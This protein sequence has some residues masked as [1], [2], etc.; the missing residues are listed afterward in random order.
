[1]PPWFLRQLDRFVP[2]ARRADPIELR[3]ARLLVAMLLLIAATVPWNSAVQAS[4]GH[5]GLFSISTSTTAAFVVMLLAY[6]RYN[7]HTLTTHLL[8]GVGYLGILAAAVPSGLLY[9]PV[10]PI[11]S[12][13]P[14]IA[15]ALLDNRRAVIWAGLALLAIVGLGVGELAGLLDREGLLIYFQ[16][17]PV[18]LN[19]VLL[20]GYISG[21]G[22]FLNSLN[23]EQRRATDAAR[24]AA[25]AANA[26]KSTFL[27][28]MSHELRTPMNGVLGLTEVLLHSEKLD[29]EQRR[30]LRTIHESGRT[31]VGLLNDILDLSKVESGRLVLEE[32]AYSPE[33]VLADV[34]RLFEQTAAAKGLFLRGSVQPGVPTAALGDP[35]RLRQVLLNLVGNA[36]KFTD[37]GG[38][39]VRAERQDGALVWQV[40]DTGI[41]VPVEAQ[42]RIFEP[43]TQADA[44]TSRRHGGTGLGLAI[45]SRLVAI[46]AG[47]LTVDSR[48]RA[49]STFTLR[50]PLRAAELPVTAQPVPRSSDSSGQLA[51]PSTP[52]APPPA[53]T[54]RVSAVGPTIGRAL[55]VED[56]PVN[57]YVA[58][59]MLERL[60][61]AVDLAE[62]GPGALQRILAGGDWDVILMD[63]QLPG[64]DGVEVTRRA[65]AA[66]VRT[67]IVGVTA[68]VRP[69]DRAQGLAAGMDEFVG[70]PYTMNE[71]GRAL[72]P[73]VG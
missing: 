39:E 11:L 35:T 51:A 56:M 36:V 17:V 5:W 40:R 58:T 15:I 19:L 45:S 71:L 8:L 73:A 25:D 65:R 10:T 29:D 41:G 63:W 55:L 70:K 67:R 59:Q 37:Q 61:Y 24:E 50:L 52:A 47:R 6:R 16:P 42:A 46:M 2:E 21:V 66:G 62:D 1:M 20:V 18:G 12:A 44:S 69:E 64:L 4:R 33:A 38:V 53:P 9:S 30:T 32:L 60:G 27:A 28:N 13:L 72:R 22:Y 43:F 48:P 7:R 68:N 49:G 31:L 34:L 14:L 23:A 54:P 57:Q 26:A 3:Q